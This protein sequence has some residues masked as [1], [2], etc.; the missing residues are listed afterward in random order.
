MMDNYIM[1]HNYRNKY[2]V[3][4]DGDVYVYIYGKYQFDP[5]FLSFIPKHVFIGK[6]KDCGMT[7]FSGAADNDSDFE[8]NTLL[9]EVE[10]RK[11][12]CI[13]SPEN[14]EFETS[15]KVIDCI[16][17]MGNKMVPYTIL[18]GENLHISYTININLLKTTNLKKDLY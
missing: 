4:I 12:V 6:S 7:E 5:P 15:D 9:P 3:V 14:T 1:Q 16:S 17:L 18:L 2:L 8:G 13:S 11:Y 10:D